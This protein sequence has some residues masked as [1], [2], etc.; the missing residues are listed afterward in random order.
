MNGV[1]NGGI[2]RSAIDAREFAWCACKVGLP[3]LS[4]TQPETIGTIQGSRQINDGSGSGSRDD[5]EDSQNGVIMRMIG[6]V[7]RAAGAA[8]TRLP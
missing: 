1:E 2:E 7:I 6:A 3:R 5:G 8:D 4:P